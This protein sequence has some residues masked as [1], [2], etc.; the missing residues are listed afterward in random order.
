MEIPGLGSFTKDTHSGWLVSDPVQVPVIGGRMCQFL[1]KGYEGDSRREEFHAAIVNFLS[2]SPSVLKEV[3]PHL[4][5]YYRDC[6]EGL[7]PE[8]FEDLGITELQSPAD[9]WQYVRLGN[10]PLVTRRAYGDHGIYVSVECGC[11]WE[12]EHGLQIIF[13]DGLRVN[14]IGPYD[15]HVTNSDAYGDDPLENVIYRQVRA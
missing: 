10:D 5:Q 11:D 9:V 6:C 8:D 2:A 13:K 15:G 3:E 12:Q 4:F 14:K 1:V 7:E